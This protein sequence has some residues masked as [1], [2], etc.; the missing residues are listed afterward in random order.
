[1]AAINGT[2]ESARA[3]LQS[4]TGRVDRAPFSVAQLNGGGIVEG[5]IC[6]IPQTIMAVNN[7][8]GCA[9]PALG[10]GY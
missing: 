2:I 7:A 9:D 10:R 8:P 1:M 6:G 3:L 5:G 4:S